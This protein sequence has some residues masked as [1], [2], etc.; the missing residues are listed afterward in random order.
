MVSECDVTLTSEHGTDR[1]LRNFGRQLPTTISVAQLVETLRYKTGR[2]RVRFPMVSL[3]FFI[4]IILPTAL[5]PWGCS[6]CNRNE[7]QEYFIGNKG[8]LC[9]GLTNLP[10]SC[11]DFIDIWDPQLPGTLRAFQAC[12]GIALPLPLLSTYAAKQLRRAKTWSNIIGE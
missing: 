8:G 6:T 2:P 10:T 9:V 1:L 5:W 3:E 4:D 12:N 7:Y 11:A